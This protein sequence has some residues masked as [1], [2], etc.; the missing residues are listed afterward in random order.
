MSEEND[1]ELE[2]KF[3]K[4]T[5]YAKKIETMSNEDKLYLYANYKQA[6]IGNND[7][8]K[9]SMFNRVEMEKWKAWMNLNGKTKEES[10]K[11]YI[12][13]VKTLYKNTMTK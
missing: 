7:K 5:E 13:K 12:K 3:K 8:E 10:M 6:L 2:H 1:V 9:P 4:Y 11:D